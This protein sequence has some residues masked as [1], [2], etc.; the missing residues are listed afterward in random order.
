[1]L[2]GHPA[3]FA[4]PELELLGFNTLRERAEHFAG[5][6]GFLLEGALRAIMEAR[7]CDAREARRTMTE[8]EHGGMTVKE[9]YARLQGWLGGRT[10]VDKTPSYSLD[11]AVLRR[12]EERFD[13][14]RYIHLQRHPLSMIRS[15]IEA[16]LNDIFVRYK[17]PFA[18]RRRQS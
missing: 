10:L 13:G 9:F 1:M 14:A 7:Q 3:L 15:F 5:R 8:F 6:N 17:H 4:P 16:K 12:A 11:A 2:G 18:P